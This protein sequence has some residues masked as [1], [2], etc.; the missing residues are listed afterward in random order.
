MTERFSLSLT[1]RLVIPAR[2]RRYWARC[3]H[4]TGEQER[5]PHIP[6]REAKKD[7]MRIRHWFMVATAALALVA[8]ANR[9]Q[10]ADPTLN[11][12]QQDPEILPAVPT[13]DVVGD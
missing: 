4:L 9:V 8:P 2:K 13:D 12:P 1:I 7:R 5:I 6:T 11:P 3:S 10:A